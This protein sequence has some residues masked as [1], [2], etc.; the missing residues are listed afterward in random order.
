MNVHT[1]TQFECG[2]DLALMFINFHKEKKT[3]ITNETLNSI[4]HI[5]HLY[6]NPPNVARGADSIALR[7]KDLAEVTSREQFI[8]AALK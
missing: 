6:S 3:P 8:R 4:A 2:T 5:F 7:L 1:H